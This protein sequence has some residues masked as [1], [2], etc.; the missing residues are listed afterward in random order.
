MITGY[1]GFGNFGDD[2]FIHSLVNLISEA[3]EDTSIYVVA[4]ALPGVKANF[5]VPEWVPDTIY[6]SKNQLGALVRLLFFIRALIRTDILINGGGSVF[7]PESGLRMAKAT[8]WL[9]NIMGFKWYAMG[10]SL[11]TGL[12]T[13][14]DLEHILNT[15]DY[16]L[17]RDNKSFNLL[18][19]YGYPE[20]KFSFSGDLATI[21]K[22]LVPDHITSE[23]TYDLSICISSHVSVD[24]VVNDSLSL[25]ENVSNP[26]LCLI[27]LNSEDKE[28]FDRLFD[29]LSEKNIN[30][31]SIAYSNRSQVYFFLNN[32]KAVI[33]T[34]LH[35]A[36]VSYLLEIPFYFYLH[37]EKCVD[38]METIGVFIEYDENIRNNDYLDMAYSDSRN[39]YVYREQSEHA[40]KEFIQKIMN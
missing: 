8:L 38:F 10:V 20:D 30:L 16:I 31:D 14:K 17:V 27:L 29:K 1:Y 26:R 33:T 22:L 23:K 18:K 21:D 37:H 40:F 36:I 12:A 28:I 5:I 11:P 34:R 13:N 24:Q 15:I 2:I 19:S 6:R 32:S 25:L 7:Q 4:K 9:K 3:T 39:S 35:G